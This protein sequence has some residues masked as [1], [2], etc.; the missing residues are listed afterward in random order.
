MTERVPHSLPNTPQYPQVD[1]SKE[2]VG[3]GVQKELYTGIGVL[4]AIGASY[5]VDYTLKNPEETRQLINRVFE[6][7]K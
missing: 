3:K 1:I 2:A 5:A 4:L 6:I 7:L